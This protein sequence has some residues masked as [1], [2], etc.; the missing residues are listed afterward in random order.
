MTWFVKIEK[1]IVPKHI[2]DQYVPAHLEYVAKLNK[3]GHEAKTGYWKE[4]E[5]GMLIFKAESMEEAKTI[6]ENDPLVRNKCVEYVIHQWCI[7]N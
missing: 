2:F 4:A 6:V 3:L 1:G 7:V 5:G